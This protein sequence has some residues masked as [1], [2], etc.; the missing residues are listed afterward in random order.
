[1]R[2]KPSAPRYEQSSP[3]GVQV[4]FHPEA[5]AELWSAALWYEERRDQ[6]GEDFITAVDDALIRILS[7]PTAFP[8]WHEAQKTT[9]PIRKAQLN[10]F[11]YLIAFEQFEVLIL[12]L[13]IAHNRRRPLYW[14]ARS[15]E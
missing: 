3:D 12:I 5:R 8:I 13:C 6:G 11:P 14:L 2:G 1:M 4:A 15:A 10:G 9:H 7:T